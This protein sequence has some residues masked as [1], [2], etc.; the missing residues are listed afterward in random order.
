MP[1]RIVF[2]KANLHELAYGITNNNA[3]VR[4]GAQSVRPD[5]HSRRLER[6]HRRR[7]G[8]AHGARRHRL[9]HRRLGAHS[10]GAVRH[11]RL[12]ADDRPLV[13]A[14]HRADLAHAR[15]RRADDAQRRRLRAARRASSPAAP[16]A[17][18][19]S[20]KGLRLGVPRGHFWEDLDA[21]DGAPDGSRAARA[22]GRGRGA[23]RGRRA[24]CRRGSTTRP[25]F[26]SRC[27]RPSSTSMPTSPSTAR[28]CATPRSWRRWRAPTSRACCRA[29][30]GEGAVP[31]AA[32]RHALEVQRPQLQAAYATTSAPRRR[33]RWSFRPR[34]LPAAPIGDDET[35]MLNGKRCRR[36]RPSFA[37]AARAA[38][39]ASPASACRRR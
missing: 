19:A 24:R 30:I 8:R 10:R 28:R 5:P 39:P 33:R 38:S 16:T 34:R 37:T 32:Y 12:P 22:E 36:S 7:G 6:R 17:P 29:C 25:A 13:A 26:R 4:R 35:V 3:G 31:E 9:G 21:R 18:A 23:G 11:R 14:G 27:T 2:G 15:H 20:L 1:A